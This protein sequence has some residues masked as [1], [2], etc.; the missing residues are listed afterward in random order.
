LRLL[1]LELRENRP[2]IFNFST[3]RKLYFQKTKCILIREFDFV[4]NSWKINNFFWTKDIITSQKPSQ[5]KV[6]QWSNLP[7]RQKKLYHQRSYMLSQLLW[8]P[9]SI[10]YVFYNPITNIFA[11]IPINIISKNLTISVDPYAINCLRDWE[12]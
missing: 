2:S 7:K 10:H 4:I 1:G 3:M 11:S 12:F 9:A 8:S 6:I 5:Y